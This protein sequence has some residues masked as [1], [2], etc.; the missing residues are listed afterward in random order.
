MVMKYGVK[1]GKKVNGIQKKVDQAEKEF[2]TKRKSFKKS[3][4]KEWKK[5]W[6]DYKTNKQNLEF[7]KGNLKF[8]QEAS[9]KTSEIIDFWKKSS[10]LLF[11]KVDKATNEFGNKVDF[12]LGTENSIEE[13]Y[14]GATMFEYGKYSKKFCR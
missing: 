10:P 4:N 7:D 6:K 8:Y 12:V 14:Y 3:G 1:T 9:K 11:D 5:E 2:G 13:G